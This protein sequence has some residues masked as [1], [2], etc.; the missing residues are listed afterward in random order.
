[1]IGV[2]DHGIQGKEGIGSRARADQPRCFWAKAAST[3]DMVRWGL[4][5]AL[6]VDRVF[7]PLLNI[8]GICQFM[9]ASSDKTHIDSS[10]DWRIGKT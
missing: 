1:M 10:R 9:I 4:E 7:T 5:A 8:L 2:G 6:G 3:G